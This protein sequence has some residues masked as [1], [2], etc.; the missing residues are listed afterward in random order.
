MSKILVTG[1]SKGIGRAIA[2]ELA[3]RGHEVV[4]TARRVDTLADLPVAHRVA[5]DVTDD[6]SVARA[7][8]EVGPVDVLVNNAGDIVVAPLESTPIA[9][10]RG[11]YDVNVLGTLRMIQAFA[12]AMRERGSGTIVNMS[13]IVG[14]TGRPLTGVYSST[15]WAIE[16]L[17]EALRL[18]LGHFGVRVIV[19]EPGKIDSGALDNP[20]RYFRAGDPYLPLAAQ[21]RR[22][23]MSPVGAVARAVADAIAAPAPAFRWPVGEDAVDLLA[24]RA[25]LDDPAF[26]VHLRS[27]LGFVW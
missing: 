14:R 25:R 24:A 11:L 1:S 15:K 23:E 20:R 27:S 4:A 9:D 22:G 2:G 8:A 26:D 18:E 10:A 21:Q 5:L 7:R 12:P 16:G 17:S 19:I 3:R 6:A 13:S